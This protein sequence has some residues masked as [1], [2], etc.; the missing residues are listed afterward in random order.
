MQCIYQIVTDLGEGNELLVSRGA[1]VQADGQHLLVS[2][3]NE[4]SLDGV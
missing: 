1:H 4:G 3:Y 2:R